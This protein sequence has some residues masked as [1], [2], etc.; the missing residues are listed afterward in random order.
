MHATL[1]TKLYDPKIKVQMHTNLGADVWCNAKAPISG[2]RVVW[3]L[4]EVSQLLFE[5]LQ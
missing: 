5:I 3:E 2:S 1:P 4:D